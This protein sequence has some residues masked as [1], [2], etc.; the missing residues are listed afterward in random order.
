[1]NMSVKVRLAKPQDMPAVLNLIKALAVFE[2][3][4]EAVA[5]TVTELQEEGFGA[6]P[7][8]KCFVAE[9]DR[10]ILGMALVYFRFS[11]WKGRS[12][13]LEDLI[14][15]EEARKQGIGSLLFDTVMAYAQTQKVRV[16]ELQRSEGSVG[17]I[18]FSRRRRKHKPM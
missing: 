10:E 13:H 14:V 18:C 1:M 6:N 3:A 4:P 7:L 11:T 12:V 5:I 2:K 17:S 9:R 8:F 16:Q 15:K